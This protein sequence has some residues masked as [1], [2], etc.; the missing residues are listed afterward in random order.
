M[1][2]DGNG[3]RF[4]FYQEKSNGEYTLHTHYIMSSTG[5]CKQELPKMHT[6]KGAKEGTMRYMYRFRSF[7]YSSFNWMHNSFYPNKRKVMPTNINLENYTTPLATAIWVMD[8]GYHIKNK[9]MGFTTNTYTLDEIKYLGD[10]LKR[11]YSLDYSIVK[12]GTVNQYNM[13]MPKSSSMMLGNIIKK[14]LVPS[15]YYKMPVQCFL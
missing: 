7:T 8:D 13:Y 12:T 2:K 11:K 14:Y 5:Y 1:E 6:R 9:G 3:S 15:M 10:M 4:A